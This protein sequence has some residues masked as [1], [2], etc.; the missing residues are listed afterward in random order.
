VNCIWFIGNVGVQSKTM[1]TIF[2]QCTARLQLGS[3]TSLPVSF[4]CEFESWPESCSMCC[5]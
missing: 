4:R 5:G 2:S 1:P 3:G